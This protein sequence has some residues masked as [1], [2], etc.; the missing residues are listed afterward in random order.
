MSAKI[1]RKTVNFNK[2]RHIV[3]PTVISVFNLIRF[4]YDF[5][6]DLSLWFVKNMRNKVVEFLSENRVSA[7]KI[8]WHYDD[9]FC[10]L[11]IF[12]F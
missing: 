11:L 12:G 6:S 2:L 8:K 5:H 7:R 1:R 4:N 3:S 10:H 9:N